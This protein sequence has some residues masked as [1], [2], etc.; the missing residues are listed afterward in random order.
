MRGLQCT[1]AVMALLRA[2][3]PL[4]TGEELQV[5]WD[6]DDAKRDILTVIRR[7]KYTLVSDSEEDGR[8]LLVV[9]K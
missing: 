1:Q 3:M 6:E 7:R 5:Q 9:S 8:K 4:P 2:L